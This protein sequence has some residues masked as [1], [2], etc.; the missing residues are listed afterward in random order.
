MQIV[1]AAAVA[2]C[3][4][5]TDCAIFTYPT[6]LTEPAVEP[7]VSKTSPACIGPVKVVVPI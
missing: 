2:D 5:A 1:V 6:F 4:I 3:V 7:V